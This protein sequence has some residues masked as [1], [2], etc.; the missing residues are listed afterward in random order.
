M[1]QKVVKTFV[2]KSD[3][4][5]CFSLVRR[6][7]AIAPR[8]STPRSEAGLVFFHDQPVLLE[9]DQLASPWF[10]WGPL[11]LDTFGYLWKAYQ[12]QPQGTFGKG[13]PQPGMWNHGRSGLQPS[14]GSSGRGRCWPGKM[15]LLSDW[16]WELNDQNELG[17][18]GQLWLAYGSWRA[19]VDMLEGLGPP[20]QPGPQSFLHGLAAGKSRRLCE[21]KTWDPGD[22]KIVAAEFW[23]LWSFRFFFLPML[24]TSGDESMPTGPL[25]T[26]ILQTHI[27]GWWGPPFTCIQ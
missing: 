8:P 20:C 21:D 26:N 1:T 25:Q 17:K 4:C 7:S 2:A 13:M 12:I 10:A 24:K 18:F 3:F 11:P 9:H 19:H 14:P 6:D 22:W 23:W 15:R 5:C 27:W 16:R